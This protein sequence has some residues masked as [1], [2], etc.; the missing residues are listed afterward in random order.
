MQGLTAVFLD[1]P[2]AD[3]ANRDSKIYVNDSLSVAHDVRE[4][5]IAHGD[6]PKL[7]IALCGYEG[8]HVMPDAWSCVPWKANGGYASQSTAHDN[9][10]ARRERIWFSK[11][12]LNPTKQAKHS[13]QQKL[14]GF[15]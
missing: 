6:D 14:T 9:P 7:R 1:P 8:E 3:T 13:G 15:A 2:Y 11:Y 5:A 4:W 12:C 10:N